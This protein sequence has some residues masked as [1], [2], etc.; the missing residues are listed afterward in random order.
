[1]MS[2]F[3]QTSKKTVSKLEESQENCHLNEFLG[4]S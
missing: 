1:M 2:K 4:Y 3:K